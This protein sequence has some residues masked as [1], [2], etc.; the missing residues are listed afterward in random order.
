MITFWI[1]IIAMTLLASGFLIFPLLN[2]QSKRYHFFVP[3]IIALGLSF[4]GVTLYWKLGA[5]ELVKKQ[6]ESLEQNKLISAE[7]E[8]LG[9]LQNVVLTLKQKVEENPDSRG[10]LLLG[11]LYLKTQ[12]FKE[13]RDAFSNAYQLTPNQ[14]EILVGYAESLYFMNQQR[15]TL[16]AKELLEKALKLQPNQ[17]DVINLLAMDA[18]QRA[19]YAL[20]IRYWKQLLSQFKEG[21]A[22]QQNLLEMIK[23]AE[24]KQTSPSVRLSVHV[25]L[26][27]PFQEKINP[28][29]TLFIYAQAL[30][31]PKIPLAIVR[32]QV[33]DLPVTVTLDESMAMLPTNTLA[34]HT[35]VLI[36][37]RISK[38]GQAI[39]ANG[40]LQGSSLEINLKHLPAKIAVVINKV[41]TDIKE[42]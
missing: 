38:T 9:S 37:A 6:K 14:P 24:K 19:D 3:L 21:S 27:K 7:I 16:K 40:D 4:L 41:L 42:K 32:K 11:R 17:P 26:A 34:N 13:A 23:T 15:L 22:E 36:I 35:Q 30:E 28:N 5:Y 39:A 2:K 1:F 10:F 20:A 8:K 25:S 29:D 18:Y 12:Q 33:R 31:G